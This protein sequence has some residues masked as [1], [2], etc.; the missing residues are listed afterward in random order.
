MSV[1]LAKET[2]DRLGFHV[3]ELAKVIVEVGTEGAE[4][5][6]L[7]LTNTFLVLI[8]AQQDLAKHII[9]AVQFVANEHKQN[10]PERLQ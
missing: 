9:D 1:R 6:S 2:S 4:T 5:D 7:A 8:Q 3:R 10:G